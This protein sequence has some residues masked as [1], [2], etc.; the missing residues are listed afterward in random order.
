MSPKTAHF[1][2]G[3]LFFNLREKRYEIQDDD[4]HDGYDICFL[5]DKHAVY[6]GIDPGLDFG[7]RELSSG[8]MFGPYQDSTSV[9]SLHMFGQYDNLMKF[10]KKSFVYSDDIGAYEFVFEKFRYARG[11][12]DFTENTS[13][14]SRR[15]F[16]YLPAMNE[17]FEYEFTP[18]TYY[19]DGVLETFV[20]KLNI[21]FN[22]NNFTEENTDTEDYILGSVD[23]ASGYGVRQ[24]NGKAFFV[25]NMSKR[26]HS[27]FFA[28]KRMPVGYIS[29][30]SDGSQ[31]AEDVLYSFITTANTEII[32]NSAKVNYY[33]ET[34]NLDLSYQSIEIANYE[35]FDDIIFVLVPGDSVTSVVVFVKTED[36]GIV[37]VEFDPF[38]KKFIIHDASYVETL[39]DSMDNASIEIDMDTLKFAYDADISELSTQRDLAMKLQDAEFYVECDKNRAYTD[40]GNVLAVNYAGDLLNKIFV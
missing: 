3:I 9:V 22:Q 17:I 24:N 39:S 20:N 14:I 35:L 2:S 8:E 19:A 26:R 40:S 25:A 32:S 12:Y 11:V 23:R 34:Y 30:V 10:L 4:I 7:V 27:V 28:P 5:F 33:K 31:N 36:F 6:V 1:K 13:Y 37:P 29:F 18:T 21:M 15:L 38:N 16:E